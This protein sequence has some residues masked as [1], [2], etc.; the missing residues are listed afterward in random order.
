MNNWMRD[1]VLAQQIIKK[2]IAFE[3]KMLNGK[4]I[5][6]QYPRNLELFI[7]VYI[8]TF[9]VFY[10]VSVVKCMVVVVD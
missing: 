9:C 4:F 5:S 3:F 2:A 8:A 7:T 1:T 6:K 10:V